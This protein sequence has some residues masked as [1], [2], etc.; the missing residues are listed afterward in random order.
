MNFSLPSLPKV[1]LILAMIRVFLLPPYLSNLGLTFFNVLLLVLLF[2]YYSSQSDK[3]SRLVKVVCGLTV[4]ISLFFGVTTN[5]LMVNLNNMV[6]NLVVIWLILGNYRE[7]N[8]QQTIFGFALTLGNYF[9][10]LGRF[11]FKKDSVRRFWKDLT[12]IEMSWGWLKNTV[13][14]IS[15]LT[16]FHLLFAQVNSDY[17]VFMKPFFDYIIRFLEYVLNLDIIWKLISSLILAYIYYGLISVKQVTERQPIS[18]PRVLMS[19]LGAVIVLFLIFSFFQSKL[20]FVN[21]FSLPFK[22]LSVYTQKGFWELLV[23]SF[24][25]HVLFLACIDFVSAKNRVKILLTIFSI[26][27]IGIVIFTYHKLV[28]LEYFFGFKDQRILATMATSL[29]LMTFGLQLVRLWRGLAISRMFNVQLT[30]LLISILI[31]NLMNVDL[32]I[33]KTN[34]ISY[35]SGDNKVKDYSYLL[36]NSYDNYSAWIELANEVK[37]KGVMSPNSEYYWG[38]YKPICNK[39]TSYVY[40][41]RTYLTDKYQGL[42]SKYNNFGKKNI[43]ELSQFNYREFQAFKIIDQH[44]EIFNSLTKYLIDNCQGSTN[45]Q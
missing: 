39:S 24:L 7:G 38:N 11:V 20:L 15:I 26:E 41:S 3:Q 9:L 13:V 28:S 36:G 10:D 17:Q 35:Y 18:W 42:K 43:P 45:R 40:Q 34:P 8:Y 2:L 30:A 16:V 4:G 29:I 14:I 31:L 1:T 22:S 32:F 19:A 25:G 5:P 37:V 27:L 44:P 12:D 21:L 33:T 23:V 6:V